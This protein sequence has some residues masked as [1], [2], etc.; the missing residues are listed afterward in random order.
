VLIDGRD[1]RDFQLKSLRDQISVVLQESVLFQATVFKNIQYGR[2]DAT[3]AEVMAAARAAR[4]DQFVSRLPNGYQTAIGPRGATLSGGERQRVA[5]ARAMIRNAPILL[6]DEPTTGLDVENEQLV[7]EALESLMEGR[8]TLLISHR[9]SLIDRVN[10]LIV[11]D[12]GRIVESGTPAELRVSGG[13]YARLCDWSSNGSVLD[14]PRPAVA[15]TAPPT[16]TETYA[17]SWS[18]KS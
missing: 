2:P 17:K 4:V 1:I 7:M 8:T 14:E 5:I 15:Q 9:L 12:A 16:G 6:L 11:V 13:I 18:G 10:R 3:H